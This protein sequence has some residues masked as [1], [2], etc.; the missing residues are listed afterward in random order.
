MPKV[1][2]IV[3]AYNIENYIER[4]IDSL[5][6]QTLKDIEIIIVNDGSTDATLSKI[7]KKAQ[8]DKRIK[9]I[10]Q[11][12]FGLGK[13]RKNGF[14]ASRGEYIL[15]I[16][17]D[18]WIDEQACEKLYKKAEETQVDI[19]LY[20][21]F[22]TNGEKHKKEF[23]FLESLNLKNSLIKECLLFNIKPCIWSKFIRRDF[24]IKNKIK[25]IEDR[26][27]LAED[28]YLTTELFIYQPKISFLDEHLYYYYQRSSSSTKKITR[29]HLVVNKVTE[30]IKK[31]LTE[32]NL[33]EECK[34]E[35]EFLVHIILFRRLIAMLNIN[36]IICKELFDL[37]SQHKIDHFSNPYLN[38]QNKNLITRLIYKL[39]EK[40]FFIGVK[41]LDFKDRLNSQYLSF[42]RK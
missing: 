23:Y 17:G 38:V 26:I 25:F 2:L 13:T 27:T 33:Y 15:F 20:H 4:C 14:L 21:Y 34:S 29:E 1:S 36:P 41:L 19:I 32:N 8:I 7:Q 22:I 9:I 30:L 16:D 39:I 40:G 18:D 31:R 28:A 12:N 6:N 5:I 24:I 11:E 42:L 37:Y 35:F 10:T 3:A